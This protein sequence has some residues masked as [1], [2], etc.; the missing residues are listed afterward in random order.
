MAGF[1]YGLF[2]GGV[3]G[4]LEAEGCLFDEQVFDG[5][6]FDVCE[7]EAPAVAPTVHGGGWAKKSRKVYVEYEGKNLIFRSEDEA[8]RFLRAMALEV[9]AQLE[10]V[11]ELRVTRPKAKKTIEKAAAKA[12][13]SFAAVTNISF[14][15]TSQEF[16]AEMALIVERLEQVKSSVEDDEGLIL[17]IASL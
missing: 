4:A 11:L 12:E 13:Q 17:A 3:F 10:K 5:D 14:K 15:D 9:E 6:I 7:E 2:D 1:D 8:S 16:R